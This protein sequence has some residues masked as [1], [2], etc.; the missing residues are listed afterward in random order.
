M[1]GIYLSNILTYENIGTRRIV[2]WSIARVD[3]P[4][5][6]FDKERLLTVQVVDKKLHLKTTCTQCV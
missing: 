4:L 6:R 5:N 1:C 3:P 2:K